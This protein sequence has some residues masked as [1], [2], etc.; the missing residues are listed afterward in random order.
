MEQCGF[1]VIKERMTEKS[2]AYRQKNWILH[3]IDD[4]LVENQIPTTETQDCPT[5]SYMH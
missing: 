1:L 4:N 3:H 5:Y 2:M